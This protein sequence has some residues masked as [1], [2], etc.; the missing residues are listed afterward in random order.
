MRLYHRTDKWQEIMTEG[1]KD[2]VGHYMTGMAWIGV[3]F[4]S[5]PLDENQGGKGDTLLI[6][7]IP[8][9][10]ISQYELIEEGKSYRE[11]LLPSEVANMYG[12]PT[13]VLY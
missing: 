12:T 9:R 3:W 5:I 7:E 13:A 4:S 6:L 1:F 8:E 10:E 2:Q 11:F